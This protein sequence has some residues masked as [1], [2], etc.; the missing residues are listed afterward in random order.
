MV[1]L[2]DGGGRGTD[3]C[4]EATTPSAITAAAAAPTATTMP[5]AT[6]TPPTTA[7]MTLAPSDIVGNE[8][9]LAQ[10]QL[11]HLRSQLAV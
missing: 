10:L 2:D 11:F 5:T 4:S 3:D 7:P 6:A 9:L 8:K 1:N